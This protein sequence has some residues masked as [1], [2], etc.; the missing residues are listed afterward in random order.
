MRADES[1]KKWLIEFDVALQ[2]Q[3]ID[4]AVDMFHAESYWRDLVSFTWNLKTAE[5]Q[6]QIRDMLQAT[7][8]KT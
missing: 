1:A 3:D 4:K 6:A 7:L 8:E 5:G 2:K